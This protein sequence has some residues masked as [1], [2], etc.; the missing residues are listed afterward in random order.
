MKLKGLLTDPRVTGLHFGR[1][2]DDKTFG[3][4]VTCNGRIFKR[5]GFDSTKAAYWWASEQIYA[6]VAVTTATAMVTSL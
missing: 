1:N 3:I 4:E 2:Q 5:V 6:P